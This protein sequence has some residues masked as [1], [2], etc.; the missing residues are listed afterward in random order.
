[1]AVSISIQ[2]YNASAD[3]KIAKFITIPIILVENWTSQAPA[4]VNCEI[5]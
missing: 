3:S 5:E 4:S 1:L 2:G